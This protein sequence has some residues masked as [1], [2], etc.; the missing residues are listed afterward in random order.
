MY[1]DS[2]VVSLQLCVSYWTS[3]EGVILYCLLLKQ[4][5]LSSL[6]VGRCGSSR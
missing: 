1:A 5:G 2:R 6:G 3:M 4:A